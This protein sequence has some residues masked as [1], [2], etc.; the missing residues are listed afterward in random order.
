SSFCL[1]RSVDLLQASCKLL[2]GYGWT[3]ADLKQ[4]KTDPSGSCPWLGISRWGM[5][6]RATITSAVAG[7]L[8]T[9]LLGLIG[10]L[11]SNN[12]N[13]FHGLSGIFFGLL[14]ALIFGGLA[15]LIGPWLS[16]FEPVLQ[17]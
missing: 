7:M 1:H 12:V 9:L 4:R 6:W 17:G 16:E 14:P 10:L 2:S 8:G 11:D 5:C 13:I 3:V 15:A